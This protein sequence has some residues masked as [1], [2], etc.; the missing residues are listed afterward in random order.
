MDSFGEYSNGFLPEFGNLSFDDNDI[1][2]YSSNLIDDF[3]ELRC[4][5]DEQIKE[6]ISVDY[7]KSSTALTKKYTIFNIEKDKEKKKE[8]ILQKKRGRKKENAKSEGKHNKNA[9]DNIMIKIKVEIFKYE[10]DIINLN[11]TKNKKIIKLNHKEIRNLQ[12]DINKQMF[13]KTLKQLFSEIIS[14]KFKNIK[15]KDHNKKLISEIYEGMIKAEKVKK[16]LDLTFFELLEIFKKKKT[17]II[18]EKELEELN[19]LVGKK[20]EKKV[21][22]KDLLRF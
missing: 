11:L 1:N 14:E 16:I 15:Y 9:E 7:S 22:L 2:N 21:D 20:D 12:I 18:S 13:D 5:P 3:G 6:I 8:N 17:E 10:R 4:I 19:L